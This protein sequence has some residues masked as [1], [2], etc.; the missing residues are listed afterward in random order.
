MR[1]NTMGMVQDIRL[2]TDGQLK[3]DMSLADFNYRIASGRFQFSARGSVNDKRLTLWTAS[4]AEAERRT[5]IEIKKKPYL[6]AGVIGAVGAMQT[7]PGDAYLFD[8]FDPT[9]MGQQTVRV[10]VVG[11][12]KISVAGRSVEATK[13]SLKVKGATQLAWIDRNG[14]LLK[15]G[16]LL[17]I[18]MEQTTRSDAL[19]QTAIQSSEDLT[20]QASVALRQPIPNPDKLRHLTLLISGIPATGLQLEGGRQHYRDGRLRIE[21]ESL[22]GLPQRLSPADLGQL[23]KIF[24]QPEPLIQADHPKIK[25]LVDTI[26]PSPA[27]I[28]PLEKVRLLIDWVGNNIEKRPVVAVPDAVSTL[29]NRMGDCNEHAMLLAALARAAGIPARVEAGLV[30]LKGRFYYHA[31]NLVYLGRW[32]S[33]DALFGQLPADVTHIRLVTGS[34][35]QQLDLIGLIGSIGLEL[36]DYD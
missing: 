16:G 32:V 15:Q 26:L 2:K 6:T 23:E 36:V 22:E 30:Y 17:G 19:N 33:A 18:R 1:I 10:D 21:K 28:P 13:I 7:K 9:T 20:L 27:N 3:P 35:Q 5:E 4:G 34:Q 12:E 14:E 11:P 29:E 25:K 24:L 31:W 8:V